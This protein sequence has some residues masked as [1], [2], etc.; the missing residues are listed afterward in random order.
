[1]GRNSEQLGDP[2]KDDKDVRG[3]HAYP[4]RPVPRDRAS[5]EYGEDT[6]ERYAAGGQGTEQVAVGPPTRTRVQQ[7]TRSRIKPPP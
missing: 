5:G 1:M 3:E 6:R 2:D 4:N 7:R